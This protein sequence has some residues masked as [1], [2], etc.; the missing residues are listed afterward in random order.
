MTSK[1][2]RFNDIVQ[3]NYI[4]YDYDRTDYTYIDNLRFKH[5]ILQFESLYKLVLLKR[6]GSYSIYVIS[7]T[8]K[9]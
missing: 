4:D 5:R 8:I 2:V 6:Y 7:F 1:Q 3:I 9:C